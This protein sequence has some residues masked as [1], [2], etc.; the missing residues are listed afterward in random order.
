MGVVVWGNLRYVGVKVCKSDGVWELWCEGIEKYGNC[1]VWE[2][3][4]GQ[5]AM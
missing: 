2:L 1:S 4:C 5:V 3:W